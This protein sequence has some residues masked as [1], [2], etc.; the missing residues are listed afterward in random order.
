MVTRSNPAYAFNMANGA[1]AGGL[2]LG[3]V[4]W[5]PVSHMNGSGHG[6]NPAAKPTHS[7][8]SQPRQQLN[9]NGG[10][11]VHHSQQG[12]N[13]TYYL[14]PKDLAAL[15][16]HSDAM[17]EARITGAHARMYRGSPQPYR[18]YKFKLL[19]VIKGQ[20]DPHRQ[21]WQSTR[22]GSSQTRLEV[23][24]SY[25]LATRNTPGNPYLVLRGPRAVV[26]LG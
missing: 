7:S 21:I 18:L 17:F 16:R 26:Q 1:V 23:G 12:P 2:I 5:L 13:V 11:R 24:H 19:A 25:L 15:T 3:M 6:N 14:R 10:G 8:A 20:V 22:G 4:L 9:G